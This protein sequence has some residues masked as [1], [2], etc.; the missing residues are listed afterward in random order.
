M[1]IAS[2]WVFFFRIGILGL[3]LIAWVVFQLIRKKK[4]MA[5]DPGRCL[6]GRLFY[7]YLGIYLL[8]NYRF[9]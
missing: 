3:A 9:E 8:F 6:H 4:K 7:Y 1:Q 2:M 5:G